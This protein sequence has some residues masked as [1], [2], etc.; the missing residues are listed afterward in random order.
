MMGG[1]SELEM[2]FGLDG[3][4]MSKINWKSALESQTRSPV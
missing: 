4:A 2:P 3:A 1:L